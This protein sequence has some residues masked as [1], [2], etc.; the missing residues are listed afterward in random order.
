MLYKRLN[1]AISRWHTIV[2]S[3]VVALFMAV[4]CDT[5]PEIT[6]T[7][8]DPLLT[9]RLDALNISTI[10][11]DSGITRYRITSPHWL[12]YD[13]VEDPYWEFP[14]GMHG[15]RFDEKFNVE[16][17]LDCRHARFYDKRK[18]WVL[19]DSVRVSNLAGER[20][21]TELLYWD[22]QTERIYSDS[23][24]VI[25]RQNLKIIGKGFESNQTMTNYRILQ[26]TGIIPVDEESEGQPQNSAPS[27]VPTKQ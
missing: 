3:T 24:I 12:I 4:G 26:P 23:T 18:V 11:S 7:V 8:I 6:D 19:S 10:I 20:F 17:Q 9:P 22:Q 15:D 27:T 13:K 2:L 21:E 1:I 16:A 5:K 25:Y 14:V